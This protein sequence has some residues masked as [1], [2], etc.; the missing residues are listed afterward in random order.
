M[1]VLHMKTAAQNRGKKMVKEAS[2]GNAS[3]HTFCLLVPLQ[4]KL[5]LS[6]SQEVAC[7]SVVILLSLYSPSQVFEK[8][9]R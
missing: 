5:K 8:G 2:P 3:G 6:S 1:T 7:Y 9:L 4:N